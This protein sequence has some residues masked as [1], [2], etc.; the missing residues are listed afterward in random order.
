MLG[1]VQDEPTELDQ[2]KEVEG[3]CFVLD[4]TLAGHLER[5]LPLT[6]DYDE[7]YWFGLRIRPTRRTCC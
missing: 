3:L 1:L 7:R 6:V 4:R 5:F 2:V